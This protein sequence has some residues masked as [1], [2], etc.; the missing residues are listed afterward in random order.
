METEI[1]HVK[2][3]MMNR[4]ECGLLLRQC[5][6]GRICTINKDGVPYVTPVNYVYDSDSDRIYIHHSSK[7]GNLLTNLK[8][9]SWVCFEV[10]QPGVIVNVGSGMNICNADQI[11][12]SV[13][14]YG[15]MLITNNEEKIRG[16]RLLGSKYSGKPVQEQT[17][18][19][20]PAKL[21][22]LVVLAITIETITGKCHEPQP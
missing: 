10:D 7:G 14:C 18:K 19:L 20:E 17:D 1:V 11:Y 8:Y 2:N 15:R 21:D 6:V 22:K 5:L 12:R 3:R 16:L 13:I 9:N 4:A